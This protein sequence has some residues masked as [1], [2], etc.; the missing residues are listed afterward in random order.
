ME[1]FASV[2]DYRRAYPDDQ[3]ED[4]KLRER[5][6]EATDLMCAAMDASDVEYADPSEPFTFRLMRICRTVVHRAIGSTGENDLPFG[7]TQLSE[8]SAQFNASVEFA[9]PSGD[10]YLTAAEREALGIGGGL[11][12]VVS[13]YA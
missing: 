4:V 8:T 1:P 11:A 12:C 2:G 10:L 5:L 13:P 6:L 9:N 3:T 7:A